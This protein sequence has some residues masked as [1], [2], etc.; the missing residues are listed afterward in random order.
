MSIK[1]GTNSMKL[2]GQKYHQ[3]RYRPYG[4]AWNAGRL[5]YFLINAL[6]LLASLEIFGIAVELL[7]RVD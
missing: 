3:G 2:L 5:K 1:E 7:F 4:R 6:L